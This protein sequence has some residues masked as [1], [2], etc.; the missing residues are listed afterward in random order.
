M[1]V[2]TGAPPPTGVRAT[3]AD[4]VAPGRC[5][6]LT[7]NSR[8]FWEKKVH[9]TSTRPAGGGVAVWAA[10]E[11]GSSATSR[12][13]LQTAAASKVLRRKPIRSI[14]PSVTGQRDARCAGR[15]SATAPSQPVVAAISY[16]NNAYRIGRQSGVKIRL[17]DATVSAL[18]HR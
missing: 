15:R 2:V 8:S 11:K 1:V 9:D 18:P 7:V 5:S 16:A 13:R 4:T 12:S 3:L 6:R 14:F 17:A 10:A